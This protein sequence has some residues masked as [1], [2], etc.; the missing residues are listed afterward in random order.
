MSLSVFDLLGLVG[1]GLVLLAYYG[2]QSARLSSKQPRF[3]LL[4]GAGAALILLS[5]AEAWNLP[6]AVIESAWLLI[7][8]NGLVRTLRH[9]GD[10]SSDPLPPSAPSA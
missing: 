3:Y 2:L 8:I 6:A 7:S 1:V 5:L 10:T 4:N 9:R